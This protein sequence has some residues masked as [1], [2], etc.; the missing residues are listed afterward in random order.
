MHHI[1]IIQENVVKTLHG[2]FQGKKSNF[3]IIFDINI[4][5]AI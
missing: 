2:V 3:N 5:S 4:N 1:P